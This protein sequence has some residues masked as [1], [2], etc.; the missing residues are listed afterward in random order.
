MAA[1]GLCEARRQARAHQLH[2]ERLREIARGA[3]S[4]PLAL[5]ERHAL[6]VA[7]AR[8]THPGA[9]TLLPSYHE[10]PH[11]SRRR[12]PH[13]QTR[14]D[15][16][17]RLAQ[18]AHD[19]NMQ[20]IRMRQRKQVPPEEIGRL[21]LQ[22]ASDHQRRRAARDLR[23]RNEQFSDRIRSIQPRFASASTIRLLKD[24]PPPHKEFPFPEDESSTVEV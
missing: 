8:G 7:G 23:Q 16:Q 6:L 10:Y 19:A 17:D 24:K 2:S 21:D 3:R 4:S 14:A 9:P 12:Q 5:G 1:V 20:R 11:L 22:R 15:L 13:A 18:A